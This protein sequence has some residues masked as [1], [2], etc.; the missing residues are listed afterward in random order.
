MMV[1]ETMDYD[2]INIVSKGPYVP[3]I[4]ETKDGNLTESK[5]TPKHLWTEND[6][7]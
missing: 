2:K 4:Q 3:L 1:L 6:K 5:R 7:Y